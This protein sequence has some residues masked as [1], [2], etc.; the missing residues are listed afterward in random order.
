MTKISFNAQALGVA[1]YSKGGDMGHAHARGPS[2][3]IVR[4][5]PSI[6]SLF[7]RLGFTNVERFPVPRRNLP[8][9]DVDT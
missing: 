6:E 1:S 5:D 3:T 9:E 7:K 2:E 4:R 8:T